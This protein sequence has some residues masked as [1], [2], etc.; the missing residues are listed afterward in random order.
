M[1]HSTSGMEVAFGG[2]GASNTKRPCAGASAK[3]WRSF[4]LFYWK[5]TREIV[6]LVK[7]LAVIDLFIIIIIINS[8]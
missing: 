2:V 6:W 7:E 5:K 8:L 4:G 1:T 3:S